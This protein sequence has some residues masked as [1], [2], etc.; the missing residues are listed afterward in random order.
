MSYTNVEIQGDTLHWSKMSGGTNMLQ[1]WPL[2]V[3]QTEK[4]ETIYSYILPLPKPL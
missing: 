1:H 2:G 4:M 3:V